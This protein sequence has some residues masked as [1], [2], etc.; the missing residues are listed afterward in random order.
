MD[1]MFA[2][3]RMEVGA[4]A[5]ARTLCFFSSAATA[6][7]RATTP[8]FAAAYAAIPATA[9]PGIAAAEAKYTIA[10]PFARNAG[11]SARVVRYAVVRLI[12]NCFCHAAGSLS[13]TGPDMA[14]P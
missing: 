12:V 9:P 11:R 6:R 14:N 7:M 5:F 13:A 2:A 3:V 10:P 8:D 1:W 4:T